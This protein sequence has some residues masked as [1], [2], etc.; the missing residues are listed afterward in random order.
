[1][2]IEGTRAMALFISWHQFISSVLGDFVDGLAH[3]LLRFGRDLTV[4]FPILRRKIW[5]N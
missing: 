2:I 1:M 4:L 5:R 3:L